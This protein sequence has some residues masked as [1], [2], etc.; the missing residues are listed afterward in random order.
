M[1]LTP[2]LI[3]RRCCARA[4]RV[5]YRNR[6]ISLVTLTIMTRDYSFE[7][8]KDEKSI[9]LVCEKL[10]DN[11]N[12]DIEI[13]SYPLAF[14]FTFFVIGSDI[15]VVFRCS[16]IECFELRKQSSNEAMF[17]VLETNVYRT[18]SKVSEREIWSVSIQPEAQI[19]IE[20]NNFEWSVE[21]MTESE[22]NI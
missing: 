2:S 19:D 16:E 17:V 9:D 11:A 7:A 18:M 13:S 15:N 20:C 14:V 10:L 6:L 5:G 22:R 4:R 8:W 3:R 12:M 21:Q 1:F